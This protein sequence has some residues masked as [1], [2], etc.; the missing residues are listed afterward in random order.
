MGFRRLAFLAVA[1]VSLFLTFGCFQGLRAQTPATLE[2]MT[3]HVIPQA[4]IDLAWWWR[5]DPE[6]IRVIVPKTL[7]MAFENLEKYPDYT[8]S[9]LQVPAIEPL[10]RFYPDYFYKIHY[11]IYN[12]QAMGLSIPN[13]HGTDETLGRFKIVHGLYVESDG[14]VPG[15]EA[16]VRQCLYGKRYYR[17]KFG[18]DVKGAWFQDAWTHPWTYPQILKKSGIDSYMFKRGE[19][20]ANDER[21]FW[22]EGPDGSRVFAYKP[23]SFDGVPTKEMWEGELAEVSKRYGVKDHIT[24]VGVGDHGGGA[25]EGDIEVLKKTMSA[26]PVNAR[27]STADKFL[28]SVLHQNVQFP[29]VKYEISPTIR[30]AYT[31][32]GEIKKSNRESEDLLMTV[33][34]FASAAMG[35]GDFTYPQEELNS[36]WKKVLLNQFHDT[37][38]GTATPDANDDALR[39]YQQVLHSASTQLNNT[40]GYV[41]SKIDTQGQG[42][43]IVIFNPLSWERTDTVEVELHLESSVS[44]VELTDPQGRRAT[45][46]ILGEQRS[47]NA[48]DLRILLL[49][50]NVPS[51]GYK[52]YQ[53]VP[54]PHPGAFANSLQASAAGLENEFYKLEID[55]ASGSLKTVFD[56]RRNREVLDKG[57]KGNLIQIIEDFGDSEGF[58]R[59]AD[60]EIDT[61]HKWTGKTI[62]VDSNPHIKV[63]E[64]GPVRAVIQIKKTSGLARFTQTIALYQRVPRIDFGLT[65]DWKGQNKMVKVSFPLNVRASDATYEIPYGTIR[66]PNKGEEQNAQK[67]VDVSDPQYGT[68]LLNDS[69]YGYDVKDNVIRL[70]VLRSPPSPAFATDEQGVHSLRYSLYP[71]F[72]TWQE[73]EVTQRADELNYPLLAVVDTPHEGKLPAT[74]SFVRVEPSNVII[75][76]LKKAEDSD[77]LIIRMY[78]TT[79]RRCSARIFLSNPVDAVHQTDLLENDLK[80]VPTDGK[81]FE[82]PLGAYSIETFKLIKDK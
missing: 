47:A 64:P 75:E 46:Q 26:M 11:Y 45:Y 9:F 32:R 22:W 49:A 48:Y 28:N 50:E 72:G 19:A 33:E 62:N 77:N 7:G 51:L 70:S 58:L 42:I 61:E 10:E 73:A 36:A 82:V 6:T 53:V 34:K 78:E 12:S 17:Y 81:S 4:H 21:M 63:L 59:S 23:A 15:G 25:P 56:K 44:G 66:R 31:T 41:A 13:P 37:I 79:G 71:H 76:A 39:L 80:D 65:M 57:G 43:P 60:G 40:L 52:T 30:G 38:S 2:G 5:Y 29:T 74:Y 55:P 68:S 54:T 67:W 8:F 18:I 24:L 16:V 3:L 1:Q 20:G 14:C 35:L 69:R 27:F